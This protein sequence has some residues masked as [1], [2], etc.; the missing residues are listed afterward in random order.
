MIASAFNKLVTDNFV[1]VGWDEALLTDIKVGGKRNI[2]V[3]SELGYGSKG[4]GRTIPPN[5]S[6]YFTIEL[7]SINE[8]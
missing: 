7:V 5:A 3:P 4:V 6:L 1:L 2:I 8:N